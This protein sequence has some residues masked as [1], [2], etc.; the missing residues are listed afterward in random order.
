[1]TQISV[2]FTYYKP[3]FYVLIHKSTLVKT[4]LLFILS[5]CTYAVSAQTSA[6]T[7]TLKAQKENI[8]TAGTVLKIEN[9]G[10]KVNSDLAELRPTISADG[11]LLFFI[12]EDHPA[13]TKYKSVSN[14]QDIWFSE[15]DSSGKWSE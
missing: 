7:G 5:S 4:F 1:M 3:W 13:N 6:D 8:I 9:L 2:V 12:C 14:S 10:I 11:N 15:R